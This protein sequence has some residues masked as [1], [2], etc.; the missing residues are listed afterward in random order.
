MEYNI[1]E[2]GGTVVSKLQKMIERI[3][4]QPVDYTFDEVCTLLNALGFAIDNKG[5]SSGS[6]VMFERE[7]MCIYIHKPHPQKELKR[8]QIKQILEVLDREGLI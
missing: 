8:Y 1:S 7:G 2:R 4:R 5:K 6:R 3:K